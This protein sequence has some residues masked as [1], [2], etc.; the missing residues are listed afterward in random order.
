MPVKPGMTEGE[1]GDF[2]CSNH[3]PQAADEK[4]KKGNQANGGKKAKCLFHNNKIKK[5]FGCLE[6]SPYICSP[7]K[8]AQKYLT[9]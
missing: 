4:R 5:Y 1:P 6:Y 9:Y 2:Q 3:R 7:A 8:N